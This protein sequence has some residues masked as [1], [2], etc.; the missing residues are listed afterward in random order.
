MANSRTPD[1]DLTTMN[2]SGAPAP[3]QSRISPLHDNP[4]GLASS[5]PTLFSHSFP[6][7]HQHTQYSL[8]ASSQIQ[9]P[10]PP[11]PPPS[12]SSATQSN[13]ISTSWFH[14]GPSITAS[15]TNQPTTSTSTP[16]SA[17][18]HSSSSMIVSASF[19][20]PTHASTIPQYQ[21]LSVWDAAFD[22]SFSASPGGEGFYTPHAQGQTP[23][24]STATSAG[25][26]SG[27][28]FVH[29]AD[30][31][32]FHRGPAQQQ[33]QIAPAPRRRVG[34]YNQ[35]ERPQG[36]AHAQAQAQGQAQSN[37]SRLDVGALSGWD[38]M[39]VIY[40]YAHR[41][42][43][44]PQEL[45]NQR[46][47]ELLSH[48]SPSSSYTSRSRGQQPHSQSH[49]MQSQSQGQTTTFITAPQQGNTSGAYNA[50]GEYHVQ[51]RPGPSFSSTQEYHPTQNESYAPPQ[52]TEFY[53]P[54]T[55]TA[56]AAATNVE[57]VNEQTRMYYVVQASQSMPSL[58]S[59]IEGVHPHTHASGP[60]AHSHSLSPHSPFSRFT[61]P[62]HTST[63]TSD[64]GTGVYSSLS[65]A[66][67]Y[68]S[69]PGTTTTTTTTTTGT[70]S[71]VD[72]PGGSG[73]GSGVSA[74]GVEGLYGSSRGRG[75]EGQRVE[76]SQGQ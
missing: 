68:Q 10:P 12:S 16:I 37:S 49:Q 4:G 72:E 17:P 22:P 39:L 65:P 26:V 61:P 23:T 21:P 52:T 5:N 48:T 24:F 14:Q 58:H 45:A 18:S 44:T 74:A 31:F 29:T 46:T 75:V 30:A 57:D 51:S 28:Q 40:E 38:H 69:Y 9:P 64:T 50:P 53:Y 60:H 33:R 8:A 34:P 43:Q 36:Q 32:A 13:P 67:S 3:S 54:T 2:T 42:H 73:S 56:A 6:H 35:G 41:Q 55:T 19:Y 27:L 63:P 11:P 1:D 71:S 59:S 15:A 47:Q 62:M 76:L 66:G 7:Q 70:S 20:D 25:A